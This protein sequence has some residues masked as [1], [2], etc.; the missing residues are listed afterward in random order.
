MDSVFFSAESLD[1]L[2]E[3][4]PLLDF[5]MMVPRKKRISTPTRNGP[6]DPHESR[7]WCQSSTD[8]F[9][10]IMCVLNQ[11]CKIC[12]ALNRTNQV[13]CESIQDD[14]MDTCIGTITPDSHGQ[15]GGSLEAEAFDHSSLQPHI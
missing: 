15:K 10:I 12:G 11:M 2:Q 4:H 9:H 5:V 3:A 6:H 14:E 7:P 1:L 8:G 13:R